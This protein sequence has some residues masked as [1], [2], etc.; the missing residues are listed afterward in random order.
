[1]AVTSLPDGQGNRA[2][3]PTLDSS[4]DMK[5]GCWPPLQLAVDDDVVFWIGEFSTLALEVSQSAEG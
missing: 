4:L 1:M 5:H 2:K 3:A